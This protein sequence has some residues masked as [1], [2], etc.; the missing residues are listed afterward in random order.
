MPMP[1]TRSCRWLAAAF[2]LLVAILPAQGKDSDH[3]EVE[4]DHIDRIE[5]DDD[6]DPFR[7][8]NLSYHRLE[9]DHDGGPT[10]TVLIGIDDGRNGTR[11]MENGRDRLVYELYKDSARS[12]RLNDIDGSQSG[13]F[14]LTLGPKNDEQSLTFYSYIE[15]GQVVKKGTYN[16]RVTVNIYELRNGVPVGPIDSRSVQVRAKVRE[17]VGASVTVNGVTRPLSGNSGVLDMGELSRTGGGSFEVKVFGNSDYELSL[18]SDN[19]GRLVSADNPDGIGYSV[20]VAGRS[21]RL[22]RGNSFNLGGEGTYRIDVQV[23][24]VSRALAGTYA[25]NLILIISAR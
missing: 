1:P 25:D 9:V 7:G 10:C 21:T 4:I 18:S 12:Q 23:D 16:D 24:D 8:A 19:A 20:S 22:T 11:I 13:L 2:L 15:P 6:Y 3:C 17:V 14:Q 5:P